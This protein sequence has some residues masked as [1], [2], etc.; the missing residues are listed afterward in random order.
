MTVNSG[1]I[2][3]NTDSSKMEI[4]NGEQWWEID[5]TSPELQTG[6][7]RGL[8]GA[9]HP[10][11][12]KID[13]INIDTTGNAQDFGDRT[14][15]NGNQAGACSSRVRGIFA[16]GHSNVDI[17]DFVTITSTGD[18]IDFGDLDAAC[19]GITGFS[20]RTRGM[21]S[22]GTTP[23]LLNTIQFVTMS[24]TGNTLD[25][26]DTNTA[27]RNNSCFASPTRGVILIAGYAN[28]IEFVTI[29]TT[30]NAANFGDTSFTGAYGAGCS[31]AVR[32]LFMEGRDAPGSRS[33][34]VDYIT[35]ATLGN[36]IDFGDLT[37]DNSLLSA[38]ASSTRAVRAGGQHSSSE[39]NI[40]DYAQIMTTGNF[41]D[42]GDLTGEY[43]G[44]GGCSNGHGGLG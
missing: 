8:F 26:G 32:G 39:A 25:F 12:A 6:G 19:H 43:A 36:G 11:T 22:G 20:D 3:F 2:R 7:T 15:G 44:Q 35:I 37:D 27:Q 28:T 17:I 34:A 16:G 4:Y 10:A 30:G 24:S 23:T 21:F 33:T 1:S 5:S 13:F 31:N 38:T 29:S 42:F 40:I 9:G 18:A 14:T 41:I